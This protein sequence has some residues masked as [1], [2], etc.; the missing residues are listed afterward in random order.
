MALGVDPRIGSLAANIEACSLGGNQP[1]RNSLRHCC[2]RYP[3]NLRIEHILRRSK[4]CGLRD[5]GGDLQ[6]ANGI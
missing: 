5:A 6:S 4:N 3:R 1:L 2:M